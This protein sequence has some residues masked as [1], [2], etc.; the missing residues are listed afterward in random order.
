MADRS[1]DRGVR[2]GDGGPFAIIPEWLLDAEVSDRAKVL[3]AMFARFADRDLASTPRKKLIADRL[4]CSVSTFELAVKE[5][6]EVGAITVEPR[7]SDEGDRTSNRYV[8]H[9]TARD[10]SP[11]GSGDGSPD[12]SGGSKREPLGTR[13][14]SSNDDPPGALDRRSTG[15]GEQAGV[16]VTVPPPIKLVDRQNEPLNTLLDVAGIDPEN[17]TQVRQAAAA[18]N[19]RTANGRVSQQG[20]V[21]LLWIEVGRWAADNDPGRLLR[22]HD[23][24]EGWS[25]LLCDVIPRKAEQ[26]RQRFDGATLTPSAL[27]KWWLEL[28]KTEQRTD[29]GMTP[30]EMRSFSG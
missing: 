28:S 18:L 1:D 13:N 4:R 25:R 17:R 23:E 22:L 14:G 6:S 20:I 27:R 9:V 5:L 30:D 7:Y 26:Y 29:G 21:H 15:I 3:Y 11:D 24:P 12:G 10:T 8:L 19:G 16:D 2:W